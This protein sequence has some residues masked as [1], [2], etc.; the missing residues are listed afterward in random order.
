METREG[1][2]LARHAW[3]AYSRGVNAALL[4]L[5]GPALKR[6]SVNKVVDLLGFWVAWQMHG[7]FDGLRSL[8]MSERTIYRQ[9]AFFRTAYGQHPDTFEFPGLVL[10]RQA[11]FAAGYKRPPRGLK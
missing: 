11:Y 2:N 6:Y 1:R 3:E 7:G 8:G 4:P 10:D 9:I 5:M